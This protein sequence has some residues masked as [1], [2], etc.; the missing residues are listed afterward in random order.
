VDKAAEASLKEV[1]F[2]ECS[3]TFGSPWWDDIKVVPLF[4]QSF[5]IALP[6]LFSGIL[7][8]CSSFSFENSWF[9]G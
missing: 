3:G 7:T 6:F 2:T 4:S 8:I 5:Q 9:L 1:Y